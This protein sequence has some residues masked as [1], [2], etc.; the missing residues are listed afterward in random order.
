MCIICNGNTDDGRATPSDG[1]AFDCP[2]HGAY[3]IARTAL[4]RF[5]KMDAHAQE[6]AVDRARLFTADRNNE[7][8][9]TS[10]DI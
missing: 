1:I 8:I 6:V 7:I 5:L 10:M 4:P 3:A 9:I 2:K